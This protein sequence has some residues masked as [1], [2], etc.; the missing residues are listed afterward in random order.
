LQALTDTNWTLIVSIIAGSAM[1]AYLGDVLGSKYGKQRISL[2]GLRP[3][4]T[5][6]LITAFTGI[7]ISVV[8]LT[9]M[10]FF[11]ENVRVA[12]FTL[13]SLRQ[14]LESLSLRLESNRVDLEEA[15][16][17]LETL[18]ND[19]SVLINEKNVLEVS[20]ISLREESEELRLELERMRLG[21]IMVQAHSLLAQGIIVPGSS[22]EQVR[23]MLSALEEK[24]RV[25]VAD[26]R[27]ETR[28]T[29]SNDVRLSIEPEQ[30]ESVNPP[31][32]S[33]IVSR[34]SNS[35][36][37]MYARI[38]AAE[39]IAL[40]EIVRVRFECGVSY[41]LYDEGETLYRK[42]INPGE[43]GFDAEETLHVFLRELKRQAIRTGILPDPATNSVGSLEGEEF[44]EAVDQLK[45]VAVPTIINAVALQD[46][47]TEGPVRIK[48]ML[49]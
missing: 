34:L 29:S 25:S 46:I 2:F 8:V 22:R 31:G 48:I 14:E 38:L 36:E 49:E 17:E 26:R 37:R 7:F 33:D 6:R 28:Y 4:Y 10:S 23:E 39:N 47:Y 21:T 35:P 24:A 11:S 20:V 5:S 12:L 15:H 40:G 27:S 42:L 9:V 19:R 16:F 1:L 13:Q 18:R 32:E 3:K 44:F 30:R 41:L 43:E 45:D